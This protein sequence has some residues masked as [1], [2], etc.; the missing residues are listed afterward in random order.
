MSGGSCVVSSH[1]WG[2]GGPCTVISRV[3]GGAG[4]ERGPCMVGSNASWINGY[5]GP[6]P[7]C[8]QTHTHTRLK[9]LPSR[10]LVGRW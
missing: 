2:P 4:Q 7:C 5:M 3:E 10:N 9:A 6:H 8:E 1:V